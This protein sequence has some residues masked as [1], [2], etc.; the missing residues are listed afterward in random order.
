MQDMLRWYTAGEAHGAA[1]VAVLEGMPFGLPVDVT[2]I[3]EQLRRRRVPYGRGPRMRERSE[4]AT[5]LA[6]VCEGKA[7]GSPIAL[8]VEEDG[9]PRGREVR[10]FTVPRPGHA[11]LAGALKY[12]TKRV[13]LV[14]ERASAR[15]TAARVAAGA[16]CRGLLESLGVGLASYTTSVGPLRYEG[17]GE[18]ETVPDPADD[19]ARCP[20]SDLDAR[21]RVAIDEA[22]ASGDSL[23]GRCR[24]VARGLPPGLGN[25]A[26]WHQRLD[27]RIAAAMM[28]IPAVKGVL[29]GCA[30]LAAE[31]AGSEVHDPIVPASGGGFERAGNRTGGLEGG[32]T[33]G[34]PLV[35]ELLIKPVPTLGEPLASVDLESGEAAPAPALR[36]DVCVVPVVGIIAEAMLALELTRSLLEQFGGGSWDELQERVEQYRRR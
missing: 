34:E 27:T 36:A 23:G 18:G 31:R 14:W 11:D 15:E 13:D 35:V 10:P 6:G 7:I 22:H 2:Q 32:L 33:T 5:I 16:V 28:S 21:M 24:A 12:G 30:E 3:D 20:D 29:I 25:F 4:R 9:S 17:G 8:L 26:Q 1:L 19:G